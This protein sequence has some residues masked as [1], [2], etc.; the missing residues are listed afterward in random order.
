MSII[1]LNNIEKSF[2]NKKVLK[3]INLT[4]KKGEIVTL[5]GSS[6]SGK[7]TLLRCINLLEQ[8]DN[9]K[10]IY[11]ESDILAQDIDIDKY[12]S[13]L[14]M[15]FQHFNLFENLTTI[16]NLILAPMKVL[17]K[18]KNEAES[19]AREYLKKVGLSEFEN[20]PIAKLS[21]G[22]KQRVAIARALCMN[23][24]VLL[25]DEPTSALD[26]EVIGDVLNVIKDISTT[27]ITMIIVTHE[28][29]FAKEVSD[30]VIYMKDGI[31]KYEATPDEMFNN[32]QDED[33][34]TFLKR[35]IIN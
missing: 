25:F 22:Q 24:N 16:E 19:T 15:V 34:K 31:I 18:S 11:N 3:D 17:N 14:T 32:P 6:G 2:N 29:G 5:I 12:R 21:G 10:I 23:P 26:P 20:Y 30:R 13:E 8:P 9:G 27:G 33:A 35:V 7:S 4:V 1:K 28:M